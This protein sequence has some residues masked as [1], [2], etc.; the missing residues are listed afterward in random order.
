MRLLIFLSM[1]AMFASAHADKYQTTK[2]LVSEHSY[3]GLQRTVAEIVNRSTKPIDFYYSLDKELC[4]SWNV[5]ASVLDRFSLGQSTQGC[6]TTGSYTTSGTLSAGYTVEV[7][8]Q[9]MR[10]YMTYYAERQR[11]YSDGTVVVLDSTYATITENY[12]LYWNSI[13]R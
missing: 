11:V 4:W 2:T 13:H 5:S 6:R 7:L 10:D 9:A 3:R 8:G 1:L 12:E